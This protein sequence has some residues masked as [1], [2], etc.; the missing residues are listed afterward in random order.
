MLTYKQFGITKEERMQEH[1]DIRGLKQ[2]ILA[3]K[4]KELG[5][6]KCEACGVED[7][8]YDIHHKRYGNINYYDLELL[9]IPCHVNKN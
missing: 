6:L 3:L 8:P 1:A 4:E 7:V 2:Y 5:V 9:C